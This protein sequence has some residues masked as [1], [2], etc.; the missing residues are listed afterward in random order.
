MLTKNPDAPPSDGRPF[1]V[2]SAFTPD[3]AQAFLERLRQQ[4]AADGAIGT[5]EAYLAG[6]FETRAQRAR[7]A[8]ER[9]TI[10]EPEARA[11]EE[12]YGTK[13]RALTQAQIVLS[14]VT[15]IA[16]STAKW[17]RLE[18]PPQTPPTA[19]DL[20]WAKLVKRV[21]ADVRQAT[22]VP[23]DAEILVDEALTGWRN[24]AT[25]QRSTH[26]RAKL[27]DETK[28]Y[29]DRV[30]RQIGRLHS[31]IE[32]AK[33]VVFSN[34]PSED[35]RPSSRT[36]LTYLT[37]TGLR[38][39]DKALSALTTAIERTNKQKK[40]GRSRGNKQYPGL[41]YLVYDLEADTLYAGGKGFGLPKKRPQKGAIIRVLDTLRAYLKE[42][43]ELASLA[44]LLPSPGRH[45]VAVYHSAIRRAREEHA[46]EL[47][48]SKRDEEYAAEFFGSEN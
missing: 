39:V 41:D 8:K 31:E 37:P 9:G 4:A 48:R 1:D 21:S 2:E 43:P 5:V 40:R 6:L 20:A 3:I 13:E 22:A 14:G 29:A 34:A 44:A 11:I 47:V 32:Q 27:L 28:R 36:L 24:A 15:R 45:P 12:L 26:R 18:P 42:Y 25:E 10:D 30:R 38:H 35:E 16:E 46:A 33:E 7:E 23:E 17:P 19:F